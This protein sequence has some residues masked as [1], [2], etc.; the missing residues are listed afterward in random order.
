MG[1]QNAIDRTD[2]DLS[3][4]ER[5]IVETFR[6]PEFSAKMRTL[7]AVEESKD[8]AFNAVNFSLF[9]VLWS[10]KCRSFEDHEHKLVYKH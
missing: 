6:D 3:E 7:F 1:E 4:T 10:L 2:E 9:Q 5:Y 8:D